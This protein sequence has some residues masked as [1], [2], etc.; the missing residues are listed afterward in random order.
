MLHLLSPE[1]LA[2][3]LLLDAEF[4]AGGA[5]A[6]VVVV[7]SVS[8]DYW[9]KIYGAVNAIIFMRN[10][11]PHPIEFFPLLSVNV[12]NGS[13]YKAFGNWSTVAMDRS[14][15]FIQLENR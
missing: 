10:F 11:V 8:S 12:G 14:S 3:H 5:A 1:C 6:V 15:V 9:H 13:I 4:A 7:C 2:P